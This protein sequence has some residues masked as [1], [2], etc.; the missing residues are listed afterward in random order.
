MS[1]LDSDIEDQDIKLP[2]G[3]DVPTSGPK[4]KV[5][6]NTNLMI[7]VNSNVSQLSATRERFHTVGIKLT[8]LGHYLFKKIKQGTILKPFNRDRAGWVP[9]KVVEFEMK[10]EVGS[11]RRL[12]HMHM[13]V[14]F[15]GQCQ[16][17]LELARPFAKEYMKPEA[18][19]AYLNVRQ[20]NDPREAR[21][22]YFN[23]E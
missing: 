20:A 2:A 1:D 10:L 15:N 14:S 8:K 11:K 13:F 4:K 12:G 7:T 5:K 17:D 18:T 6:L 3:W 21:R 22:K 19:N 23:P 9:P 16:L